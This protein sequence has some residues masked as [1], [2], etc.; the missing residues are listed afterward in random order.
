M[1]LDLHDIEP[2][3][4]QN[5]PETKKRINL[6]KLLRSK[7]KR[8]STKKLAD[9]PTLWQI[10]LIPKKPFL[11]FPRHSSEKYVYVPIGYL[12]PPCIPGDAILII[13][14]TPMELFGLLTSKM[15]MIWIKTIGGKLET[16][17]R[18]SKGVIYN[19]FPLPDTNYD[20][21]KSYAQKILDIRENHTDSTLANLYDP[22]TMP[23]DLMKAHLKLDFA[24]EKLYRKKPFES[25]QERIEFLLS[26]Y[27]EMIEKK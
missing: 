10:N 12:E 24:V 16:R 25:D 14:N 18:Y 8:G 21:L 22:D 20:G 1:D 6:V 27:E 26:K 13:E 5:L 7:S 2:N 19:T 23:S 3:V 11:V 9:T 15:H 17:Y 4:L